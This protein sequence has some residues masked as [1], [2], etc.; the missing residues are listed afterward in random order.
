MVII[1]IVIIMIRGLVVV[2]KFKVEILEV[3]VSLCRYNY[4]YVQLNRWV[5]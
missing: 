4:A 5:F 1:T 3:V 2:I